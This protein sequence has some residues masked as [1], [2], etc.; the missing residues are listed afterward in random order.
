MAQNTSGLHA[1]LSHPKVYSL[2]Q[3]L[4]GAEAH[5]KNFAESNIRPSVGM[6]ILDIGCGPCGI[7]R[8]LPNTEYYGFDISESYI[9]QARLIYGTRGNFFAK[10]FTEEYLEILPK[11]DV[12]IASG[13]LHHLDDGIAVDLLKLVREAL[14]PGGRF[15]SIDP[16]FEPGQNP[17]ARL[18]ISNDRGRNVRTC[19][20]YL[21]LVR[22]AFEICSAEVRHRAWIPYTHCYMTCV[23]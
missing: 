6:R 5:W 17:I 23:R 14:Q 9:S 10:N 22:H 20:G 21:E 7:L 16:V 18:I 3:N 2:F 12:V 8:Y 19:S 13:L 4:M 1:I 11:F 15:L